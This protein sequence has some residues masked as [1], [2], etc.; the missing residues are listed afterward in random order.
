MA[1]ITRCELNRAT[2]AR[3]GLL[4]PFRGVSAESAV[5]RVGSL[6]AQH[7]EWPPIALASRAADGSTADLA[8]ALDRRQAARSSLMRI[9]IH[10]VAAA[11]LWPMFVVCQPLRMRQWKLLVKADPV[12]SS[13]GRRLAAAHATAIAALRERPRSSLELDRLMSAEAGVGDEAV[14]RPAWRQPENQIVVRTAWRHFAAFVPL[15]HVP[16]SGEGYGRS[17][18]ALAEDWLGGRTELSI[19]EARVS[20]ARRYLAA[21]GPATLEDLVAYVARGPGG[22]GSWRRALDALAGELLT[23]TDEAGRTVFDLEAAPRPP[24]TIDAPPRLLARWDSLLLSHHPKARD[25]VLADEHRPLVF[26]KN[27]DVLPTILI[28][29]AV[30]GTWNL[31]RTNADA[32]IELRP[33]GSLAGR[34]REGLE[35]EADRVLRLVAPDAGDRRVVFAT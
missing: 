16:H 26:S 23:L 30:S 29:G 13:L 2:L 10:V 20:V 21:F 4:E 14:T 24:A 31:E 27:A 15:V 28:D 3:Q 34:D 17:L 12:D 8:G 35:A 22:I 19:E 25:R 7:P 5:Q 33:F 6:Q 32:C 1:L 11:D 9:T 18:Y